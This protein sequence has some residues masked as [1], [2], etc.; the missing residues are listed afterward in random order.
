V[1]S[2]WS[3]SQ[4]VSGLCLEPSVGKSYTAI[5]FGINGLAHFAMPVAYTLS[6]IFTVPL[7]FK[8]NGLARFGL[9]KCRKTL[10]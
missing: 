1:G 6:D 9:L 7:S 4:I 8:I 10:Q 5:P 2:G 3:P